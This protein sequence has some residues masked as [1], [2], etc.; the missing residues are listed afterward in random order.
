MI[1]GGVILHDLYDTI[2][3]RGT[4]TKNLVYYIYIIKERFFLPSFSLI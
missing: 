2:E 3:G 4:C 1:K